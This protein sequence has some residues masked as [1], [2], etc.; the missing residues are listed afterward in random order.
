MDALALGADEGRDRLRKASVSCQ[1]SADPRMSEWGNLAGVMPSP[2]WSEHIGPA[3]AT[4]GIETSQYPEEW[5]ATATP[6]VAASEAG[7]A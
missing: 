1:V 5:K 7:R 3:E 2:L 4:G 6:S